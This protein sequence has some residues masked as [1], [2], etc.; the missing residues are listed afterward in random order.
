MHRYCSSLALL[1]ASDD[2]RPGLP[3][4][5]PGLK[6]GLLQAPA[7]QL[8]RQAAL[9]GPTSQNRCHLAQSPSCLGSGWRGE[10]GCRWEF[11]RCQLRFWHP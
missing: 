4:Q 5:G 9:W 11:P 10:G 8:Q 3:L 2:P 1:R 7:P 6:C